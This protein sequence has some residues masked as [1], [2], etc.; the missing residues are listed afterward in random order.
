MKKLYLLSAFAFILFSCQKEVTNGSSNASSKRLS[1][2]R[3]YNAPAHSLRI[4]TFFYNSGGYIQRYKSVNYD[5]T[6]NPM[7]TDSADYNFTFANSAAP[8]TSYTLIN[9]HKGVPIATS[10]SHNLFYDSQNRLLKDTLIFG[11][12][13]SHAAV[14][15]SYTAN[16]V[17]YEQYSST[18]T[19]LEKNEV[20]S[21][22][23]SNGNLKTLNTYYYYPPD[24]YPFYQDVQF[25]SYTNPFYNK[26]VANSLGVLFYKIVEADFISPYMP[27]SVHATYP[28][29]NLDYTTK[30]DW[31]LDSLGRINNGVIASNGIYFTIYYY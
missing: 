3:V 27:T 24:V 25:S 15:Y 30:Y 17:T 4:D 14:Y 18:T 20:D 10:E 23:I 8:P 2:F 19:G 21:F 29:Q 12:N 11:E 5:S 26:A 6:A 9:L 16:L 13:I 31:S 7:I 22:F 28:P 1:S